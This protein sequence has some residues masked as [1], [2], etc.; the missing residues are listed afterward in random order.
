MTTALA[1]VEY[2]ETVGE[3]ISQ[4]ELYQEI[5]QKLTPSEIYQD[6]T[7][8]LTQNRKILP[9]GTIYKTPQIEHIFPQK[10]NP[11]QESKYSFSVLQEWEGHIVSISK[12]SFTAR[13]VDLTNRR[14][15]EEEEAEF[16]LDD[17]NNNDREKISIG[18]IFRW[19]IGY[20]RSEWGTKERSSIIVFRNFPAWNKKELE[21]NRKEAKAWASELKVE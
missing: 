10:L 16:S 8:V 20:R 13:L 21:K 19:I 11:L 18:S 3:Q 6:N 7:Q 9:K 12:E 4:T 14:A 2:V 15:F 1:Q 5:A 17:L